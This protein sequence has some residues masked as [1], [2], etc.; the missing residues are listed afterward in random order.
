MNTSNITYGKKNMSTDKVQL[1]KDPMSA[2][3]HLLGIILSF[4]GLAV[5][6][7][8]SVKID[9]AV[10]VLAFGIYG[11]TSIMLYTASTVY[12]TVKSTPEVEKMLRKIDHTMVFFLIAG[13]YT[14]ICMIALKANEGNPRGLALLIAVWAIAILG[15]VF[16]FLFLNAPRWF[17]TVLY[18]AMG[19]VAIFVIVPLYHILPMLGF[20]CLFLGGVLYTVG[21]IIYGFKNPKLGIKGFGFHEIFHVFVLLGS[22]AH[23]VMMLTMI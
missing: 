12:H 5:L 8:K 18:V 17:Y 10:D 20:I 21:A 16:K 9:S 23:Y 7:H 14:P 22:L 13:T 6:M 2:L 3:T 1:V 15:T 19:W 11:L 4:I